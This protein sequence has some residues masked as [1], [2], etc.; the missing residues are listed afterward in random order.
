MI[1]DA[2]YDQPFNFD[3][4]RENSKKNLLEAKASDDRNL[5]KPDYIAWNMGFEKE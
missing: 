4:A 5:K 3:T 2:W 1:I